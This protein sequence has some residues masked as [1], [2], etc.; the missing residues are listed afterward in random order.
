V[1]A[2]ERATTQGRPYKPREIE[3]RLMSYSQMKE[4][5][6]IVYNQSPAGGY[7]ANPSIGLVAQLL[8]DFLGDAVVGDFFKAHFAVGELAGQLE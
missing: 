7:R 4:T 5:M 3:S 6:N 2:F 8:G 1:S